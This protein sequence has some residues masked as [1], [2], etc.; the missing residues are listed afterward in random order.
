MQ[1][2]MYRKNIYRTNSN[3][4]PVLKSIG[5]KTVTAW[6]ALSFQISAKDIDRDQL[7]YSVNNLPEGATFTATADPVIVTFNWI[8]SSSQIG[9]HTVTFSVADEHKS[10][11]ETI[12]IHVRPRRGGK[13]QIA[14]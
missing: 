13:A 2:P 10:V 9:S 14:F 4:A 7:Y 3:V 11:Q 1:W 6:D 12:T 8:P 5:N